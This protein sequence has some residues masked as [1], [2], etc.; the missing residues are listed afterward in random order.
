MSP[1]HWSRSALLVLALLGGILVPLAGPASA[2]TVSISRTQSGLVASDSMTTGNTAGWTFGV[3][4]SATGN[5]FSY[6]EDAQGLH[7]GV[8]SPSSGTWV[9]YNAV[10][11]FITAGLFHVAL[12]NPYATVTDGVFNPGF[13]IEGSNYNSIIACESSVDSTGYSWSLQTTTNAGSS[14]TSLWQGGPSALPHT[15]DCTVVT[16][17]SNLLAVYAGGTLVFSSSTMALNMPS[18]VRVYFEDDSSS[19]TMRSATFANYYATT[20]GNVKVTGAP[21][22][23]TAEIVDSTNKVLASSPVASNGTA[24]FQVG[25]FAL[26]LNANVEVLSSTGTLFASTPGA[27]QIYGGDV[28]AVAGSLDPTSTTVS[29]NPATASTGATVAFTAS[30]TD[31]GASPS[32][33]SGS[34]SWGDGGAGGS[35]SP[36]TC[37]LSSVSSNKGQCS[38]SYTAPSTAGS[39]TITATY[40]G[41]PSHS[42]SPGTSSLTTSN[43]QPGGIALTST[44]YASGTASSSPYQL[45]IPNFNV[46]TASNRL[47]VVGV[48]SNGQGVASMTFGGSPLTNAVF[49][50]YNND[51]ELWYLTNPSGTGNV[52]VTMAGSTSAVVGAYAFSGVSQTNPIP[53]T[54]SGS[55]SVGSSPTISITTKYPNSWVL[56]L[57]SIFG[58]STLGSPTCAQHWEATVPGAITGASS[59]KTASSPG[60]VTCGWAAT[61]PDFWDDVAIEVQATATAPQHP[62]GTAVSPN[63]D[64]VLVGSTVTFTATVTDLGGTPSSPSGAVAW[65]DGGAGGSFS[66]TSCAPSSAGSSA[67]SCSVIYSPSKTGPISIAAAYSGDA[68]HSASSGTSSLTVNPRPTS[69][70]VSSSSSTI[71]IGTTA[72]LTATVTDSGASPASP[73][74]S[75]SWGDGGLGGSFSPATCPLSPTTA[76]ASSCKVTYTAP[77]TP[78]SVTITATFSGDT[79]HGTSSGTSALTVQGYSVAKQ[80]SGQVLFDPLNN[81]TMSQQQLQVQGRYTYGGDAVGEGAHYNYDENVSGHSPGFHIGIQALAPGKYAGFYALKNFG[82]GTLYHAVIT[83][84]TRTIPSD[85]INT[86]IYVQTGNGSVNYVSCGEVT[87]S[88]GTYWGVWMATG[89]STMAKTSTNLWYDTS[90]NQALTRSCTIVTDGGSHLTAYVDNTLVYSNSALNLQFTRPF[91]MFLEVQTSY[92]GQELYGTFTNFYVSTGTAITLSNIPSGAATVKL[93]GQ[94][95]NTLATSAV[96]N[97]VATMDIGQF[98]FP[99]SVQIVVQRTDGTVLVSSAIIALVGGDAY[100]V[101]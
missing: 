76:S 40:S 95:G 35:F 32:T 71:K 87:S 91:M 8:Q 26:P 2:A 48:S 81:V 29:P 49:S 79:V 99:L 92:A 33:P 30:A 41:D 96:S 73:S 10:S 94:S 17:G 98:T 38:T 84:P 21:A 36:S 16:N 74:G 12:T 52:V 28:Y 47:L 59:S 77:S 9:N 4:T 14:W 5:E 27:L 63:P 90:A 44:Q 80:S 53:T 1:A 34:V 23:G 31:T 69:T 19:T 70:V 62:T 56:D 60:Q 42:A 15:E 86:G 37:S 13:Y 7:I 25:M 3:S 39:E 54:A 93:V 50:F 83:A 6:N 101:Q 18:P 68:T 65:S 85:Y 11:P 55:A 97:G 100:T 46:G 67:S 57:P 58:G 64:S 89:N 22:G 45:T 66:P 43:T 75:I 61:P 78:S 24:A 88:F 82:T 20:G 51:A 72:T